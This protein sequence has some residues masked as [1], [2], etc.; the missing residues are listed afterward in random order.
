VTTETVA[1]LLERERDLEV[2]ARA[3]ADAEQGHGQFVLIEAPAGLGKTSLLT[4]AAQTAAAAG[5]RCFRARAGE[6]ER[7]F[8]YGCVRQ[9][10]EPV[11][12][13]ASP[14]ERERLFDGAAS[15][16]AP[17]FS[18]AGVPEPQ[19]DSVF[20]V[21]HGLYWLV[22]NLVADGPALVTVDDLHWCGAASLRFL[23]YL[24]PRLDGLALTVV[25]TTRPG[26]NPTTELARLL[27]LPETQV[28]SP[29]P[30]SVEATA[31]LCERRLAAGV[32]AEFAAACHDAT[33]GNPFFLEALLREVKEHEGRTGEHDAALVHRFG[34]SVVAQSVLLRLSGEPESAA[35]LLRAGAVLGDGASIA[36]AA[37][38]AGL[39]A[40]DA[41][42]AADRLVALSIFEAADSIRF[43]HP[44][45]REAVYADIGANERALAHA[46]A[47]EVL[48]ERG[49]T[50]E[51]IAAQVTKA[52]P[53][54][55]ADRVILL[56]RVAAG[57]LARGAPAAAV[58]WLRRALAEPPAPDS[59]AEVLL[60]LGAAELRL[61]MPEAADHLA[62]AVDTVR[63][64]RQLAT[65]VRHL[66]N[67]LTM[68]DRADE[69]VA[70]IDAAITVVERDDHELALILEAELAAK[71]LQA[72]H[73][74][75]APAAER[76]ARHRNLAG[77]THG[78][79]LV[80]ASIAFWQ[81]RRSESA[82]AA[83]GIIER[84]LGEGELLGEPGIDVVGPFYALVIG[85]LSTDAWEVAEASLEQALT[86]ARTRASIPAMAFLMAH[87]GWFS[88]R[89]GRVAQAEADARAS[90]ELLTTHGIH[91][92]R[93]F[94]L[95][96]LVETLLEMGEPEGAAAVLESSEIG[97]EIPA[98]L[99]H[100][101]LL[102]ARG[103]LRLQQGHPGA[104]LDDL[105]EFGRRDELWGAANPLASRWRS[106]ACF[107]LAALGEK[108][109]ASEMAAEDLERA[110]RWGSASGI[111][112]ALR[113]A[114]LLGESRAAIDRLREAASTLRNSPARLEHARVLTDLGAALRRANQRAAGRAVLREAHAL[115]ESLNAVAL[116]RRARTELRAAGGRSSRPTGTGLLQ[117]TV[118]ERRVAELA[119]KG[120]SNPEIAQTLFV[121]RKTVETHLGRV[122]SKLDIPGR[123]Q[124]AV[125]WPTLR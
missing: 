78:E 100:N 76:L 119:A 41:A 17:L 59:R 1:A 123:T 120:L 2:L 11:V 121:T 107:A 20:S 28:R 103:L 81:A 36:E 48:A 63:G 29:A 50:D 57:A 27:T 40:K 10:L 32:P 96:L 108:A 35:D 75:R 9:L 116:A 24:A 58:A 112:A 3:L 19:S 90:F 91:L 7:D 85:L 72:S 69:A 22:N 34:P 45:V 95:A 79:R 54:H 44:I 99:A 97:V 12:A 4:S 101:H 88:F 65:A 30:L 113:A 42:S 62:A 104:A 47:A 93:H 92:G 21:L 122:Y 61:A 18:D 64:P 39:A 25:A 49:A 87:R 114:A 118:S 70:A 16:A 73:E 68:S 53:Q 109:R 60:E 117:L 82:D 6:L 66:A 94:A 111:G 43:A 37:R 38:L 125:R 52:P 74:A 31:A 84:T 86:E 110:R 124:L 13:R 98:G 14:D 15:L 106:H 89:R 26:E 77:A 105:L 115:A 8:A 56:R 71:A 23:N 51:R 5:Y 67:A 80:I 83:A 102:E 33:G 55:D 46:R